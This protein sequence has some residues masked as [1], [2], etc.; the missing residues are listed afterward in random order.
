DRPR[1]IR[2]ARPR[3]PGPSPTTSTTPPPVRESGPEVVRLPWHGD[4]RT[5]RCQAASAS[6]V[7]GYGARAAA[8]RGCHAAGQ[9]AQGERLTIDGKAFN[10]E[11]QEAD[12][13]WP[14]L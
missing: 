1:A 11:V 7:D 2:Q 3:A 14:D 5:D 6:R 13:H 4:G 9:V 12:D 8:P 10:D